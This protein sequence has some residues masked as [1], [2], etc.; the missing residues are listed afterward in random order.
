MRLH[1][2]SHHGLLGTGQRRRPLPRLLRG[3]RGQRSAPQRL[4]QPE[5]SPRRRPCRP[6]R[7]ALLARAHGRT[8][9]GQEALHDLRWQHGGDLEPAGA[10]PHQGG[11][12]RGRPPLPLA[13]LPVPDAPASRARPLEP[14]SR[15][16]LGWGDRYPPLGGGDRC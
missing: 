8:P 15:Q 1:L 11:D 6:L 4:P 9:E 14:T 7:A 16:C 2:E 5:P 13:Y 10:R 3:A 12:H